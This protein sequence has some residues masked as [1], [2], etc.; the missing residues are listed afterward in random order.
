MKRKPTLDFVVHDSREE[1]EIDI[2]AVMEK[3]GEEYLTLTHP[4]SVEHFMDQPLRKE[5]YQYRIAI[6]VKEGNSSNGHLNCYHDL[7]VHLLKR[8]SL[9]VNLMVIRVGPNN[10]LSAI[11]NAD[12]K[13]LLAYILLQLREISYQQTQQDLRNILTASRAS[14]IVEDA[15]KME[16]QGL[17]QANG[18]LQLLIESYR[19]AYFDKVFPFPKEEVISNG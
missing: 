1:F 4:L 19:T 8:T 10:K 2:D 6:I 5:Q 16:Y 3:I 9:R 12:P 13:F 17:V 7:L 15:M 11:Y 14:T 18:G